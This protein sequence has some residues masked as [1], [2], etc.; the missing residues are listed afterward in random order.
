MTKTFKMTHLVFN[1]TKTFT[2][3]DPPSWVVNKENTWW[4]KDIVLTLE[5]GETADSDFHTI[6]RL[7]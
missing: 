7:T 2:E 3:D 6:L 1:S 4:W 5:V